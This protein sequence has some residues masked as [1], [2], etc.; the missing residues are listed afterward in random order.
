MTWSIPG[1]QFNCANGIANSSGT[2]LWQ[3]VD[4]DCWQSGFACAGF[5]LKA[6][7]MIVLAVQSPG[8]LHLHFYILVRTLHQ[9]YQYCD[10]SYHPHCSICLYHESLGSCP[11]SLEQDSTSQ[12]HL[13]MHIQTQITQI[14]SCLVSCRMS[15]CIPFL[16]LLAIH[17]LVAVLLSLKSLCK[18]IFDSF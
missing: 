11:I 8:F 6:L 9:V 18:Q 10:C 13:L 4:L 16:L 7:S 15:Q 5:L 2:T 17:V 1:I 3:L 14:S 12:N